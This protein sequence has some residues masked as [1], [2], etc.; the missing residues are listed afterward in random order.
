MIK[1]AIALI[2][3]EMYTAFNFKNKSSWYFNLPLNTQVIYCE[4]DFILKAE[5]NV[6]F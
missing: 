2:K 3:V 4:L 1:K 5:S 6:V